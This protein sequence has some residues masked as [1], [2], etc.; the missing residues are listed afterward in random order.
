MARILS[1]VLKF[2]IQN[3]ILPY[4]KK[5]RF[6]PLTK[7]SLFFFKGMQ[8]KKYIY[9]HKTRV[10]F[11]SVTNIRYSKVHISQE[12]RKKGKGKIGFFNEHTV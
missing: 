2:I 6:E 8:K 12:R 3:S 4:L 1:T 9:I 10:L 7:T 11:D 5:K